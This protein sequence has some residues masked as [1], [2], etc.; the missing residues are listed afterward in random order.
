MPTEQSQMPQ[1]DQPNWYGQASFI[2]G[3]QV[4]FRKSELDSVSVIQARQAIAAAIHTAPSGSLEVMQPEV[5]TPQLQV[6]RIGKMLCEL[7][8][9]YEDETFNLVEDDARTNYDLAA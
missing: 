6:Q 8:R 9:K 3:E 4:D 2:P 5:E 1:H 7:R